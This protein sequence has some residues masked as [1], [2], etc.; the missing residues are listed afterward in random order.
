MRKQ[1]TINILLFV[2]LLALIGFISLG[3]YKDDSPATLTNIDKNSVSEITIHREKQNIVLTKKNNAWRV[4]KPINILANE[5]RVNTLLALLNANTGRQYDIDKIDLKAYGLQQPRAHIQFDQTHIYFGKASP[6]NVMRY[7]Q[8][9]NKMCLLFD[10][11][12]PLIR[13]QP[14]SFIDLAL[15]PP[16]ASI[17]NITL[18]N[19]QLIKTDKN[20]KTKPENIA[21][22]DQ[23][24][25]LLQNWLYAKAFAV[26]H[27]MKRKS[28]GEIIIEFDN[29]QTIK[30]KIT[31]TSPWLILARTDL[32]IEYHLDISQKEK[33]LSFPTPEPEKL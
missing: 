16:N 7:L 19:V 12:Y 14:T 27:F 15:L 20:W 5:F 33:L 11:L 18:P 21:D 4:T 24:Q 8:V 9:N 26:H 32:D 1:F 31:D 2:I 29:S 10:D 23:I 28:L 22:A 3:T 17:K 6:V 30:F 25:Q 13:S